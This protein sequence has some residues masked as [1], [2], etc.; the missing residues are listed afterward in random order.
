MNGTVASSP[1]GG[2]GTYDRG[3]PYP[4][5]SCWGRLSFAPSGPHSDIFVSLRDNELWM[6]QTDAGNVLQGRVAKVAQP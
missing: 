2:T 6:I 5:Q 4:D 3:T 1:P